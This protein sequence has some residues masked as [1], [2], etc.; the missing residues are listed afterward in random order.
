MSANRQDWPEPL[1]LTK[2]YVEPDSGVRIDAKGNVTIKW[3]GYDYYIEA[4][5]IAT[6]E[7]LLGWIVHLGEKSWCGMEPWKIAHLVEKIAHRRQWDIYKES[8]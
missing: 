7:R 2:P 3:G 8:A 1:N 5:R 6:P 4:R